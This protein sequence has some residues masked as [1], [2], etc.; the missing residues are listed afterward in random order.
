MRNF[1]GYYYIH[2]YRV[3]V[4]GYDPETENGRGYPSTPETKKSPRGLFFNAC[5]R[6]AL[7]VVPLF[8][9]IWRFAVS[10]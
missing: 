9:D 6:S 5:W 3:D 10:V 4:F 2:G 7:P 8:C 1:F